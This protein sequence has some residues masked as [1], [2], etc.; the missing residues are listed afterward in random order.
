[1]RVKP[2]PAYLNPKISFYYK[3][4]MISLG[5]AAALQAG[6]LTLKQTTNGRAALCYKNLPLLPAKKNILVADRVSNALFDQ[7]M[8][9]KP[10]NDWF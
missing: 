8:G 6:L 4:G 5:E 1:M 3:M 9:E 10:P 2:N 7:M